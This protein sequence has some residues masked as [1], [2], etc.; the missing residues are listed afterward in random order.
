MAGFVRPGDQL[1]LLVDTARSA[2]GKAGQIGAVQISEER[3]AAK[4]FA[5]L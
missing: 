1:P 2:T 5:T 4:L 3:D